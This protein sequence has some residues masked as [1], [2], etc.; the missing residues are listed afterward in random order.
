MIRTIL[1]ALVIGLVGV[2]KGEA[3]YTY[4]LSGQASA[5]GYDEA[6]AVASLQG[7]INRESPAVYVLSAGDKMPGYWLDLMSKDG[8]WMEGRERIVVGGLDELVKLAGTR[9]K[10]AVIW[11]PAV[12]ASVDVATT[13]AGAED[14]VVVSPE[15]AGKDLGRWGLPV[16]MDLRGKFT[17]AETGSKKNDAYRW[18]IREYLAKGRCSSHL[19]CLYED[20]YVMRARGDA[21]YVV[22][23]DWAGKNRA[24]VFDLSP[25]GDE[26]PGDDAGQKMGTDLETYKMILAEVMKQ[27]AGKEMTEL[28]GFFAFSKYSHTADHAS[29]HEGVPT[30]WESVWLMSPYNCYQNTISSSCFNQ[31]FHSQAPRVA[32]KQKRVVKEEPLAKKAYVCVLM[33]D[34]DSATPLYDFL[35]GNWEDKDRGK[36]PLAWGINPDLLETYPDLIAYFYSTAT[37]NDTFTSDASAAGYM[38]PN[39]ILKENLP[40]FIRH[41]QKFFREADM[42]IAPMVL[43]GDQ[44]SPAVKDA[45]A[46]FAPDG[47]AMI[48]ADVNGERGTNPTPQVWKGMPIMELINDACNTKD[49]GGVADVMARVIRER[50][51]AK[52]GFYLFRTVWVKPS[53]IVGAVGELKKRYPGLDVEV[54]GIG[55]F[56]E[57]FK[58]SRGN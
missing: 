3:I 43:D 7:V 9:V 40:L 18:A 46:Q 20:A 45:F 38:N 50:G 14:L 29:A 1:I 15:M 57:L 51:D 52:P 55:E 26:V 28:T 22:T 19:L 49:A 44:P 53:V 56:F 31:S 58:K 27:A 11:D 21:G 12:P 6:M 25:W 13:V 24:F 48:L 5:E 10:G 2:A 32:L 23:R 41:N 47:F 54:V 35:A 34:Y 39:R 36:L 8:R 33:S 42:S 37:A 30:E 4:T 17:G 16:V